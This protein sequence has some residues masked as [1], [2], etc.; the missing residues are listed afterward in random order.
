MPG[1]IIYKFSKKGGRTDGQTKLNRLFYDFEALF[2]LILK[3]FALT[4]PAIPNIA[5][6][7]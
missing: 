5:T 4:Y 2:L 1:N 7:L 3:V 6:N